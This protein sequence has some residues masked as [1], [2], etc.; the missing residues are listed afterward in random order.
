[1]KNILKWFLGLMIVIAMVTGLEMVKFALLSPGTMDIENYT[2]PGSQPPLEAFH[3][4][5]PDMGEH[6]KFSHPS[7]EMG[8]KFALADLADILIYVVI[9]ISLL[10][11]V[12]KFGKRAFNLPRFNSV[13]W[14][15]G[16]SDSLFIENNRKSSNDR[17]PDI[18]V[19]QSESDE[20]SLLDNHL[21]DQLL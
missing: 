20:Y 17:E 19:T 11:G 10:Y 7:T 16:S 6:P 18:D 8:L 5:H 14:S 1:M 3:P 2:V 12:Y 4:E 15:S 13:S 21:L 9:L